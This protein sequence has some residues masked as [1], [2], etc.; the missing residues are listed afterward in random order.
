MR[1]RALTLAPVVFCS[2]LI[3]PARGQ[4]ATALDRFIGTWKEDE[5]KRQLDG[6][7]LMVFRQGAKNIEEL[8]G[9][10][11]TPVVQP[12][13][14]D[15][16]PH[17]IDASRQQQIA[18]RQID[19][20]HYERTL[21]EDG[22]LINTRTLELSSGGNTLTQRTRAKRSDGKPDVQ[23]FVYRRVGGDKGL[24]G[25]WKLQSVRTDMP[26]ALHIT[27]VGADTVKMVDDVGVG[28]TATL[29]G[30]PVVETGLAVAGIT[31]SARLVGGILEV[32]TSR[33]GEELGRDQY[34]VSA[35]GKTL[36]ETS[37]SL[38]PNAEANVSV[39]VKQ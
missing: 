34:V 1:F 17:P 28:F 37:R 20:K 9:G 12:V 4:N 13:V 23:T 25:Q 11:V 27:R 10:E 33:D 38:A 6:A 14:F 26:P 32:A 2:L 5:S 24:V 18:W 35:D 8:R 31:D 19:T 22:K 16:K 30:R 36:T 15:A 3:S 29:D 39:Y 21:L 7:P